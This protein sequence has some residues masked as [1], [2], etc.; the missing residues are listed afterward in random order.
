M[1]TSYIFRKY[2]LLLHLFCQIEIN[3]KKIKIA[4]GNYINNKDVN[5]LKNRLEELYNLSTLEIKEFISKNITNGLGLSN[6]GGASIGLYLMHQKSKSM[7]HHI[8]SVNNNNYLV[9]QLIIN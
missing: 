5:H 7:T 3:D 1:L 4:L 6:K 2:Y 9:L 8:F